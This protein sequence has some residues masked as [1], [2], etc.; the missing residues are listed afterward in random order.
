[1]SQGRESFLNEIRR[2]H[3]RLSG[4]TNN[5][6]LAMNKTGGDYIAKL[7]YLSLKSLNPIEINW[8]WSNCRRLRLHLRV[9]YSCGWF[10]IIE[11]W[12]R[13]CLKRGTRS[14]LEGVLCVK[15]MRK[16]PLVFSCLGHSL[17]RSGRI[18]RLR[19]FFKIC[20]IKRLWIWISKCVL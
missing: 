1:M 18:W 3:I 12:L 10:W 11:Y 16:L 15:N 14:T 17:C 2:C 8:W 6:V 20:G 19:W 9:Y 13:N 7:D 4:D 5:S